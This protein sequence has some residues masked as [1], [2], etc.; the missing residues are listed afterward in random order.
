MILCF[1]EALVD[2]I[3]DPA[4]DSPEAADS[5]TA[6]FGGAL[7]NVAV[8]AA[9]RGAT[10]GLAGA[11]G[12]DDWGR[13]LA[14]AA[15]ARGRR[16]ALLR[17]SWRGSRPR[18]RSRRF[19]ETGAPSF[20]IYGDA[21]A[22]RGRVGRAEPRRRDRCRRGVRL[23]LDDAG[24]RGRARGDAPRPRA[25]A[26]AWRPRLLRSEHPPEPLGRR[27]ASRGRRLARG[28]R[29]LVPGPR[30]PPRGDGD[31]RPR[32]PARCR[33][34]IAAIGAELAV[35]TLG[36]EGAVIRGACEAEAPAPEVERR[37]DPRCRRRLHGHARRRAGGAGWD[38]AAR[39]RALPA[40][41]DAAAAACT[42][43]VAL[44]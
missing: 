26:R 3:Q 25:R 8:A 16:P 43:S 9:R 33:G 13:W 31:H 20:E 38:P 28:D 39:E 15:R 37:L 36:A 42:R 34:A 19:D 2:L 4:S 44:D 27:R 14:R 35:V 32:R 11:A 40:A 22:G 41:L 5:F 23:Q 17:P 10:A 29:G 21:V 6:H 24:D 30:Q 1:G 7:A 18:S 12:D